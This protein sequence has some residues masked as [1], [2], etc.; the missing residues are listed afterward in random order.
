MLQ[1]GRNKLDQPKPVKLTE[2]FLG[3]VLAVDDPGSTEDVDGL[4]E[5][6]VVQHSRVDGKETHEQNHV[7]SSEK[8]V[9]NLVVALRNSVKKTREGSEMKMHTQLLTSLSRNMR[10]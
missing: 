3:V 8:D 9:P 7:T 10:P 4:G 1:S 6:V 5:D 2:I